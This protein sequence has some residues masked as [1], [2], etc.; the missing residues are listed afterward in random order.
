MRLPGDFQDELVGQ[1]DGCRQEA[2]RQ[3]ERLA[4]LAERH[5]VA[6]TVARRRAGR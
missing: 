5:R 4:I 3:A 1:L 6:V 2:G